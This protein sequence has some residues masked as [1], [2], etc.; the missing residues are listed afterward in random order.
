MSNYQQNYY[1]SKLNQKK[2]SVLMQA[3]SITMEQGMCHQLYLLVAL[4]FHDFIVQWNLSKPN[5]LGTGIDRYLADTGKNQQGFSTLWFS[6]KFCLCRIPF[7]LWFDLDR[8]NCT[9]Y[10]WFDLD[11]F[12]CTFYLWFD[13]DRFNCTFYLW[14]DLDRFNYIL[15]MIWFRQVYLYILFMIWFR[16]V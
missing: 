9:F 11:R 2:V 16:Q 15:F 14:F 10:L 12:N 6:L 8:F 7:Y 3:T 5:F 4:I 13:L 1:L